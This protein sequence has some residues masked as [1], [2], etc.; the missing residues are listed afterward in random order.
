M[1]NT[2]LTFAIGDIHGMFDSL[3]NVLIGI[4]TYL[5]DNK[6]DDYKIIFLGDYI[7]RGPDSFKVVEHIR[8]MQLASPERIITLRGNHEQMLMDAWSGGYDD[9]SLFRMNGGRET[10]KSYGVSEETDLPFMHKQFFRETRHYYEDD[11][12]YFVHA[13]INPYRKLKDQ[14]NEDRLWIREPFLDSPGPFEK[15]IVHGHTP[16]PSDRYHEMS[17]KIRL[18]MDFAAV[19]GGY[20]VCAIFNDTEVEPINYIKFGPLARPMRP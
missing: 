11:L 1:S 5:D 3:A 2:R 14:T 20:L 18:N 8:K 15:Y 12:R 13:G 7:D 6:E 10:L 4:D 19:F 17:S 9:V 16:R